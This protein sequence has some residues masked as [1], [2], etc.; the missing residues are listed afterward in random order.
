M[1]PPELENVKRIIAQP[2]AIELI[3]NSLVKLGILP[4]L[5]FVCEATFYAFRE[6]IVKEQHY[7]LASA[8]IANKQD[9]MPKLIT[10]AGT[11]I[12]IY[13]FPSLKNNSKYWQM[14]WPNLC[15]I[16]R[17]YFEI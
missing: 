7:D 13:C 12:E 11:L 2:K 8:R 9:P 1:L 3:F 16:F 6:Y 4:H 17:A 15:S 14:E 5:Q 10:Q